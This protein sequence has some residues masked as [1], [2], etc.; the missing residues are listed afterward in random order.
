[1]ATASRYRGIYQ[2]SSQSPIGHV[3]EAAL[4]D[5]SSGLARNQMRY[6][7]SYA[8]VYAWR[9]AGWFKDVSGLVHRVRDGDLILIF[10]DVGHTYYPG[11]GEQWSEIFFMF[12]GPVFDLWRAQGL[13]DPAHPIL[14]LQPTDYW[15]N[16]FS[17][18][19]ATESNAPQA[20]IQ[21]IC[22]VQ[23]VLADALAHHHRPAQT[24]EEREWLSQAQ[25]LLD[26]A[27]PAS[28]IDWKQLSSR[29]G[30]SYEGFRKRFTHLAGASPGRYHMTRLIARACPLLRGGHTNRAVAEA[31]GFCDEYH[32]S[33]RFKQIMGLSPTEF[34]RRLPGK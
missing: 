12:D 8:A 21:Q 1:M 24:P 23:Q 17:T 27:E 14:N 31:L 16:R 20:L 29:C 34:R 6:L 13:L 10:P 28:E 7:G 33:R 25:R 11:D 19:V 15:L 26:Q 3:L 5:F 9:A 4:L 32:F 2:G 18:A 30:M 22:R